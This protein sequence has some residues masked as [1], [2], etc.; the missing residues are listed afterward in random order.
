MMESPLKAFLRQIFPPAF[1][2][3]L[4]RTRVYWRG[5]Y[6][7]WE[8]AVADCSGYDQENILQKNDEATSQVTSG[9]YPYERDTI[10]FDQVIYSWPLLSGLLWSHSIHGSLHVMD[11]GGSLGSTHNQ[12]IKF[13]KPL[14]YSWNIVE[15][16]NHVALGKQKYQT[17][18]LHFFDSIEECLQKSA[19]NTVLISS[20]LQYLPD[21]MGFLTN[22][23]TKQIP[24][25]LLDRVSIL[26]SKKNRLTKQTVPSW[27][28]KASY[29]CWFF[30][31][32]LIL[33]ALSSHYDLIEKF[34]SS[35][36]N[37]TFI[38]GLTPSSDHG[39]IFKLKS[40]VL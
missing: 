27:I 26:H 24:I 18:N 25:I 34:E 30:S 36:R 40:A 38:D 37:E 15:Q 2:R 14:K 10:L 39:Y 32:S 33:S 3:L 8:E 4:Q 9:R 16:K 28:Y 22:L 11:V 12:N 35:E 23:K 7:T 13:L 29:P 20:T 17:S 6:K 19:I 5:D 1:M 21:P 31:E